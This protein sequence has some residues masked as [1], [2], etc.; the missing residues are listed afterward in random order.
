MIYYTIIKY[1]FTCHSEPSAKN[2]LTYETSSDIILLNHTKIVGNKKLG[3]K[4]KEKN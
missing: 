3:Y 1:M 4:S 2:L